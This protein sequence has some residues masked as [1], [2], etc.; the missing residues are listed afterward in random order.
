MQTSFNAMLVLQHVIFKLH[1]SNTVLDRC[2]AQHVV[3]LRYLMN[4]SLGAYLQLPQI[5][6]LIAVMQ[7]L[8]A[9]LKLQL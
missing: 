4:T 8:T 5:A 9:C 3:I 1:V 6:G 7:K 2:D